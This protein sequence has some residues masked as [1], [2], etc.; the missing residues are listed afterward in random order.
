[1]KVGQ[2]APF[3][4]IEKAP[5]YPTVKDCQRLFVEI[6]QRCE[7]GAACPEGESIELRSNAQAALSRL[8]LLVSG[9]LE[10]EPLRQGIEGAD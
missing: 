1:M 4:L 10:D 9:T 6:E 8:F 7:P 2:Y 5:H 3:R